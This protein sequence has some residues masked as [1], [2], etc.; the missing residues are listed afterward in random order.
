MAGTRR[1]KVCGR[2][3][4]YCKTQLSADI[5]R[6]QDVACSKEHGALYFARIAESRGE[7]VEEPA[8][9][10]VPDSTVAE[11]DAMLIA[12]LDGEDAIFDEDFEN[13]DEEIAIE[14]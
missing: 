10:H 2:E 7:T 12:D 6:W 4:D 11:H 14:Q 1:C 8:S 3:Y 5:F 13:S 9:F